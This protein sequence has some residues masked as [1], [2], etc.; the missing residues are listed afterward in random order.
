L[1]TKRKKAT[2]LA[3]ACI[4]IVVIGWFAFRNLALWLVVS[5]PLPPSLDAVFTFAGDNQRII[6]S[7]KLFAKYP[8]AL[9]INSYPSMKITIPL[10]KEGLDTSRIFIID[11]C[12]NTSSE[13]A[14]ITTWAREIVDGKLALPAACSN[15]GGFSIERP[16]QIGL[17]S[18]PY[19]M[20][21]IRLAVS[22]TQKI[23]ACTMY[24]LP[25]PFEQYGSAKDDYKVWWKYKQLKSAVSLELKKLA[26]YFFKS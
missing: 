16:L 3:G 2:I 8:Q 5:D 7:K 20:R 26:Y 4:I 22:R 24:Y 18:T 13:V 25:V 6:Y 9:W 17:V 11:T 15:Q 10:A 19:H 12:K 14:F 1:L 23:A 21:R